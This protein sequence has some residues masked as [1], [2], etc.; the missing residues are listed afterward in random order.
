MAAHTP[1]PVRDLGLGT[2]QR[3]IE[4]VLVFTDPDDW[5]R[6]AQL[7]CDALTG[8]GVPTRS[9]GPSSEADAAGGRVCVRPCTALGRKGS[10]GVKPSRVAGGVFSKPKG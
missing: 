6:D 1:C 4:A 8:R 3:P 10:G 9:F 2:E 7:I 5:Y